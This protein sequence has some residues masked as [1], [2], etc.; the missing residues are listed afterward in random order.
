MAVKLHARAEANP[1]SGQTNKKRRRSVTIII[2]VAVTLCVL[3]SAVAWL[4][5]RASVVTNE[6]NAASELLHPIKSGIGTGNPQQSI[7][8]LER[9]QAHTEAAKSAAED[10]LWVL[11]SGFPYLGQNLAAISEVARSADDLSHL[12]LEP[13]VETADKL[14]WDTLLPGSAGANLKPLQAASP[15]INSAAHA[16]RSSGERLNRIDGNKLLPQV[17]D[18]LDEVRNQISDATAALDAAADVS[19]LLPQLLGSESRKNYLL[20]VQNNAEARA[21]GGIPGA[22]AVLTAENGQLELAEQSSAGD[23]GVMAPAIPLDP[24]QQA[25]YSTRMG[26]FMQ[27]VN[28]TPDFPSAASTARAMWERKTGERVD[29]VISVDPVTLGYILDATGPVTLTQ[30]DLVALASTGLPTELSGGNVVKVLLSDV[31]EKIQYPPLQDV[32]FA[33]VAQQVFSALSSGQGNA[34]GLVKGISRGTEEGRILFW[35]A[36][37]EEQSVV[38]KYPISGSVAGPAVQAAQF[39]V[40]FNDGTGAKMDYYVKRT[41]QLIKE[42]SRDGYEQTTVRVTSTNTA[43]A[44]AAASLPTYVT[45]DG[46]SGVPQGSVQTNVVVYGPAQSNVE[47]AAIDGQQAD[48]A[49]YLHKSRPVGVL[50]LQLAPG[51]SKT[52]ELTFGKIVQHVEPSLVVTPSVQP[53]IDVILPTQSSSCL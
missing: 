37:D 24:E 32:Y 28:L 26:K 3:G 6:L 44:D 12:A 22:V 10:P 53:V 27:D 8:A 19:S 16:V 39:G 35:S 17:A 18:P 25:I 34:Q 36:L 40:Y 15:Q 1:P 50:A 23:I 43:P 48:F 5:G 4:V 33:G 20:I 9:L 2:V 42:C 29:G 21:S 45:G 51:E 49:P 47:T 52:L 13:L 38:S 30:P 31:Y 7:A 41:V 14:N 46:A 11:A